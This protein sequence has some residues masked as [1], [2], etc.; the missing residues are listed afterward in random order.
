MLKTEALGVLSILAVIQW[1]KVKGPEKSF[2]Q[3]VGKES[4][5]CRVSQKPK[6][7]SIS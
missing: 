2:L 6:E 7:E 1:K 5:D 3:I 4:D